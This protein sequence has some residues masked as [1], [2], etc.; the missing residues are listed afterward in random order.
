M[1]ESKPNIYWDIVGP[2]ALKLLREFHA[3]E[4]FDTPLEPLDC[5][6]INPGPV[7]EVRQRIATFLRDYADLEAR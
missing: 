1:S 7:N 3:F 6:Y 4:D 2:E 5:N